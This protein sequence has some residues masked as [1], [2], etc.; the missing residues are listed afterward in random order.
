MVVEPVVQIAVGYVVQDD[1][2]TSEAVDVL[3]VVVEAVVVVAALEPFADG[4]S[5]AVFWPLFVVVAGNRFDF[6]AE[7]VG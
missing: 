7:N 2:D 3:V 5:E 6:V 1:V 4:T